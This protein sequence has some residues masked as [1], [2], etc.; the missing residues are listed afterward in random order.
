MLAV[1]TRDECPFE[2]LLLWMDDEKEPG[3][4]NHDELALV[5]YSAVSQVITFIGCAS[6]RPPGP[7]LLPSMIDDRTF[8][9]EWA[10][11]PGTRTRVIARSI[12]DLRFTVMSTTNQRIRLQIA[13]TWTSESADRPD[14]ATTIVHATV[15]AWQE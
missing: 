5:R 11:K 8:W 10:S 3:L 14:K 9:I 6:P 13:L 15:G 4:V 1:R 2:E 7:A 12:S